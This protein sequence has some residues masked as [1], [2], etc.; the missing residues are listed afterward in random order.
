MRGF[1]VGVVFGIGL[2]FL[3]GYLFVVNGGM[4]VPTKSKPLPFEEK[5]AA[6]SLEVAMRGSADLKPTGDLTDEQLVKGAKLY[7]QNCALC[8]GLPG[9]A[10][11]TA[12]AKGLFPGPPQLFQPDHGVTEDPIGSTYWVVKN[13]IRLTGMPGFE[14]ALIDDELWSVSRLV[15]KANALPQEAKDVLTPK[16]GDGG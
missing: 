2:V 15:Q 10:D 13:G 6:V 8:H 14:S 3:A 7:L 11:A 12:V 5:I 9:Q 1:V 4:P 16:K